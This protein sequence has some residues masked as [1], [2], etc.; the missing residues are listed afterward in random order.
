[1]CE[2]LG[3]GEKKMNRVVWLF[4]PHFSTLI[5]LIIANIRW[6]HKEIM[7]EIINE[8]NDWFKRSL[9]PK[10][11]SSAGSIHHF[12]DSF[13][14]VANVKSPWT[15]CKFTNVFMLPPPL[16]P[17]LSEAPIV[18]I[19]VRPAIIGLHFYILGANSA[20]EVHSKIFLKICFLHNLWYGEMVSIYRSG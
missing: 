18:F 14:E 15:G 20:L 6:D 4:H 1:M 8:T 19:C 11:I 12:T 10:Q 7:K 17:K 5:A 16:I 9:L 13:T 3:R 2:A